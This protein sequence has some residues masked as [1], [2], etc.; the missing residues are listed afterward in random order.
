MV[1][2][3]AAQSIGDRRELESR[4]RQR[5][6]GRGGVGRRRGARCER[7]GLVV[8]DRKSLLGCFGL[9]A[10]FF[11]RGVRVHSAEDQQLDIVILQ[12]C[13]LLRGGAQREGAEQSEDER[14]EPGRFHRRSLAAAGFCRASSSCSTAAKRCSSFSSFSV[15]RNFVPPSSRCVREFCWT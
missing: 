15:K 4:G 2:A 13:F 1:A 10:P 6:K 9:H 3:A 12:R 8:R 5:R 11:G 7:R 14:N